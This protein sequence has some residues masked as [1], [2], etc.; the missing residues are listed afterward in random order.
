M[1]NTKTTLKFCLWTVEEYH[2]IA[3]AGIFGAERCLTA[4]RLRTFL[5][6]F[7]KICEISIFG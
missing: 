7:V 1:Q 4:M 3:E 6:E 2:W 5:Q